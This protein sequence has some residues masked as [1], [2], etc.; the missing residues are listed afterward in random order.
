MRLDFSDSAGDSGPREYPDPPAIPADD[1]GPVEA[2]REIALLQRPA[3]AAAATGV[4]R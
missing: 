1:P 3:D 4:A 2:Q